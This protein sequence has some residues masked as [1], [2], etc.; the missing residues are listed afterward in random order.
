MWDLYDEQ[1]GMQLCSKIV[2][3]LTNPQIEDFFEVFPISDFHS[4]AQKMDDALNLC[5]A[6]IVLRR[7]ELEAT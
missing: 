5:I 7:V 6:D 3:P 2:A 4:S 1:V